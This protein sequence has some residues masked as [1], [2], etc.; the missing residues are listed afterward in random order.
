MSFFVQSTTSPTPKTKYV[1]LTSIMLA[2][3]FVILA[4]AQLYSY[5]DFP[6]VVANLWLPGGRAAADLWAVMIVILEVAAI[7]FLLSMKLS[8]AMRVVSMLAGWLSVVSWIAVTIW[9]N[10]SVNAVTNGAVLGATIPVVASWYL[11]CGFVIFAGILAYVSWAKWPFN[12]HTMPA[13]A[14][15]KKTL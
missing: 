8:P 4:V 7:P 6:D 12:S 11:V 3:V 1:E 2:A 10:V 15:Q 9:I 13:S 14:N 5:E